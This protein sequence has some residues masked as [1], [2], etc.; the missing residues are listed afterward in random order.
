MKSINYNQVYLKDGNL[1]LITKRPL[2]EN[3]T[4]EM[5]G[6]SQSTQA[7]GTVYSFGVFPNI[8]FVLLSLMKA[9]PKVFTATDEALNAMKERV[10]LANMPKVYLYKTGKHVGISC[11]PV[12]YYLSLVEATGAL[13]R[14]MGIYTVP[15]A[16]AYDVIRA[17]DAIEGFLPKFIVDKS[18]KQEILK[19]LP[20]NSI[21][22]LFEVEVREIFAVNNAYRATLENFSN[23]N[24]RV[25]GDLLFT[26][27][28]RYIDKT[29]ISSFYD[30]EPKEPV[31]FIGE[32]IDKK[33]LAWKHSQFTI[34][35]AKTDFIVTFFQRSW[36][37]DKFNL[38]DEVLFSGEYRRGKE[39]SGQSLESLLEAKSLDI[40]PIYPQSPKNNITSKIILNS[41]YEL[42]S[43]LNHSNAELANYMPN[44]ESVHMT[45]SR[46]LNELHFPS[47]S[48]T[49]LEALETLAFY[50]L[51]YLQILIKDRKANETKHKGLP[52]A[53]TAGGYF[54][55]MIESLPW[56]LTDAQK[57]GIA[58]LNKYMSTSTAEQVLLSADVGSGKTVLAQLACMQ[59]LDNGYQ[60]V[61]AG[62]TEVLAQQLY[63]TFEK[64][65]NSMPADSR[66]TLAY[67]SGSMKAAERR[68]IIKYIN[69]GAIDIVV[70]THS[71]LSSKIEYHNLGLVVIDE[72]QKF[73]SS[74]REA[75]LETRADGLRPDLLTQTATPIPRST[76]QAFYG[77][78]DIITLNGKPPG[79]TPIV[80]EWIKAAPKTLLNDTNAKIWKDIESEMKAG[81]QVFVVVPMVYESRK[82]D[83]A[84]VEGSYKKLKSLFKDYKINYLHG[85][86]KKDL[87]NQEME[88]FRS[89]ESKLLVA[90]TVI[91]V[92][93]DVPNATRIV[94]LSADR[95]GASSLHQIRGRVGRSDLASKCYLVSEGKT[96]ASQKRLEALVKS[97]DGFEIAK[98]DLQTRGEG[99]LFGIR[100]AGESS[101][102]FATLVDHSKLIGEAQ[103]V[104]ETIYNSRFR[105]Q[106]IKDAKALLK[107]GE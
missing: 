56:D 59:A 83:A 72:Q 107:K 61:L 47:S 73:G 68:E 88:K 8:S 96:S 106:A 100:Q 49:Y 5:V 55:K 41:V 11:P 76:A 20:V 24:Y 87:Q 4:R 50:E 74:Q 13:D 39:I 101:M 66:P 48:Y 57:K 99:D 29:Q 104:A 32:I 17:L 70:G 27:P 84:S 93:V 80:T 54:D 91:E 14:G 18:L 63:N 31:T 43:R 42:L 75:L 102:R 2:K 34:R 69:N 12:P 35:V 65:I 53:Y 30:L 1:T 44:I 52:K 90:S 7:E 62:P 64:A 85:Q 105:N 78:I 98:V 9:Y 103:E 82:M 25:L 86:M 58:L 46:A 92:G 89:G 38:G 45:L 67:L 37:V 81:H 79:R 6:L 22:D 19:E 10:K 51:V 94:I 60:S 40:V 21:E 23:I 28:R 77:D 26:Q 33:V 95:M 15:I 3:I 71:V 36:M 16:R 97:D